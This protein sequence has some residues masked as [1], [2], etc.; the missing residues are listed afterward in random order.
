M[1]ELLRSLSDSQKDNLQS[2][3]YGGRNEFTKETYEALR[4]CY[5]NKKPPLFELKFVQPR[6]RDIDAFYNLMK[7]VTAEFRL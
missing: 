6:V 4:D 7:D 3:V 1:A 5:I 2:I